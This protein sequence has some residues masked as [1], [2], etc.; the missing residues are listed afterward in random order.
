MKF[1]VNIYVETTWKGRPGEK[2][3]PCGLWST[4]GPESQSPGRE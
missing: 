1:D 4:K 2:A 3:L